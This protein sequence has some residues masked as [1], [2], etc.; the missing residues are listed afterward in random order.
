MYTY[1]SGTY[2]F[3]YIVCIGEGSH[4]LSAM[5]VHIGFVYFRLC[6]VQELGFFCLSFLSLS[7]SPAV[8]DIKVFRVPCI[9]YEMLLSTEIN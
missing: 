6:V 2:T 5:C 4:A 7:L 3:M 9:I 8:A 1:L